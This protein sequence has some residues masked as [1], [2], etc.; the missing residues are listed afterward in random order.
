MGLV[1]LL[2]F[3][4]IAFALT[5]FFR[6]WLDVT[7]LYVVAIGCA[8]NANFFTNI[9]SPVSF[10]PFI[11]SPMIAL[12]AL[13]MYIIMVRIIDHGYKEAKVLTYTSVAAVVVSAMIELA[14]TIVLSGSS[15]EAWKSFS[16]Y[17]F[18]S[19]GTLIGVWVMV[20]YTIHARHHKVNKYLI[21]FFG[22]AFSSW[23]QAMFYY[24]GMALVNWQFNILSTADILGIFIG[25]IVCFIF[26][27]ISYF[28]NNRLWKPNSTTVINN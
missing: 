2:I 24:G 13:F 6:K 19:V 3:T 18:S 7:T 26:G 8:C 25:G 11:F 28:V 17:I 15:V 5:T 1:L 20:W 14:N 27:L 12:Y 16:Y 4:I 9:N 22:M 23:L 10:G 21:I